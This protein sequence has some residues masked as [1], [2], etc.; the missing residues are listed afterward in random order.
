[1]S[2]D[3]QNIIV[4]LD[5]ISSVEDPD[6]LQR[7]EVNLTQLFASESPE[8]G[9]DALLRVF[10]R[11]PEKDG[12]GIFWSILSGLETLPNYEGKLI[13]SVM[14]QPSRFSLLMVNRMLNAD[15]TEVKGVNL[16]NLLKR[17]AKDEKQSEEIRIEARDFIGWQEGERV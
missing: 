12:Y 9:I 17:V 6:E 2:F 3:V 14:R 11:F 15:M 4:N 1:M 16:L 13:E 5:S 10:E 7:L 8:L